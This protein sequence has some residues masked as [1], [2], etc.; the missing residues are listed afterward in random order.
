MGSKDSS[1]PEKT[2]RL[3]T[4]MLAEELI[5]FGPLPLSGGGIFVSAVRQRPN[6]SRAEVGESS[7]GGSVDQAIIHGYSVGHRQLG[8]GLGGKGWDG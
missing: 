4:L 5:A 8:A 6:R 7:C 2:T 1:E 3:L